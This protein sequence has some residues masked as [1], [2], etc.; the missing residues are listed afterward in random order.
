M[1]E[2]TKESS[3]LPAR[4]GEGQR[5]ESWKE[6]AAYLKKDVRTVQRWEKLENLPVYRHVHHKLGTVYAYVPELDAWWRNGHERLEVL[7]ASA[8]SDTAQRP[9]VS[10]DASNQRAGAARQSS[11]LISRRYASVFAILVAGVGS[12]LFFN[13]AK[14]T[15]HAAMIRPPSRVVALTTLPGAELAPSFSP[16]GKQLAFAWTGPEGNRL[17]VYV[18]T[19]AT[20]KIRRLTFH[21]GRAVFPA[22]SPDGRNI[23]FLR[24]SELDSGIF[25]VSADGGT[26][27][28]LAAL[29][30]NP[31]YLLESLSWSGNGDLLTYPERF[32]GGASYRVVLFAVTDH[33]RRVLT[34]PPVGWFDISPIFSPDG[35]TVAF[36]RCI[37]ADCRI[38]TVSLRGEEPRPLHLDFKVVDGELAWDHAGKT[39]IAPIRRGNAHELWRFPVAEGKAELLYSSPSD[40][41]FGLAIAP[42]GK[43]LVFGAMHI[44]EH[45]WRNE[46]PRAGRHAASAEPFITSSRGEEFPQ[47]SPD[48]KRIAFQSIRSGNWDVWLCDSD[49]RN[50]VQL[51]NTPDGNSLYPRWSPDSGEIV[52][53]TRRQGHSRI[54]IIKASGGTAERVDTEDLDAEMPSFS[55]DGLEIYFAG[56]RDRNWQIWKIPRGGGASSQI[57]QDGGYAP[58]ASPDNKWV[59][60]TK[61]YASP[62]IWRVSVN[63]GNEELVIPELEGRFYA[64]W[65]VT[66]NGIY[67]LN[68]KVKSSPAIHFFEFKTRKITPILT[69]ETAESWS[70][71][72]AV[73][74]KGHWL[75]YPRPEP[76]QSD[77]MLLED[78]KQ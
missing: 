55:S 35:Q 17:D 21:P 72:L 39:I 42:D 58:V 40:H 63:G 41:L 52:Y 13:H 48:E 60:Y 38:H 74:G 62:G 26:E 32:H 51:T 6:I 23:A 9:A 31:E 8:K 10:M 11:T 56:K 25:L 67:F 30:W 69:L 24:L 28:R 75:L 18:K 53:D 68:T 36:Y 12:A 4:P 70:D 61:S 64:D 27:E 65:A 7:A 1:A 78:L 33:K 16:D 29:E 2:N 5:L 47:V 54:F 44:G 50:P 76:M 43:S 14:P 3:D 19:L 37:H 15:Q 34:T 59:Y 71:G 45:I 73:S 49:A 22:W 57:T 77:L 46:L 66:A 20:E